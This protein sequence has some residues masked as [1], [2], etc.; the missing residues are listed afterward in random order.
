MSLKTGDGFLKE[1]I[2]AASG[3]IFRLWIARKEGYSI[4]LAGQI[5]TEKSIEREKYMMFSGKDRRHI[6]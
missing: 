3:S 2:C 4:V 1:H 5:S 6:H